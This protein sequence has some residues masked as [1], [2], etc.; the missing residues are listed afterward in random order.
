MCFFTADAQIT[1]VDIEK[2]METGLNVA[3]FKTSHSTK[4][5]KIKLIHKVD[6][7]ATFLARKYG[8]LDW[9]VATCIELKTCVVQTGLLE[10]VDY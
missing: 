10:E 8:L 9:P 2:M 4:G 6:T 5:D 7:A 3:R 1:L